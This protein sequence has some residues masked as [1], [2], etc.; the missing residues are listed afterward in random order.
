MWCQ[1]KHPKVHMTTE[2]KYT[3]QC[4]TAVNNKGPFQVDTTEMGDIKV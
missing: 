3:Y 4:M 2:T 1:R